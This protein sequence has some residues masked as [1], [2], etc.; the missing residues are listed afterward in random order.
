VILRVPFLQL[1]KC[2]FPISRLS[3]NISID[4][5]VLSYFHLY[6]SLICMFNMSMHLV[7]SPY[8]INTQAFVSY[9]YHC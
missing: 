8:N 7:C 4:H 5:A 1:L 6:V 3:S 9:R 2:D